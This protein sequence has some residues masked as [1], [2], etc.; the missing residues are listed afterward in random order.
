MLGSFN[1]LQ[2]L[3][4]TV[5]TDKLIIQGTLQTRL[6]RLTDVM[7]EPDLDHL[8]LFDAT[9]MELGSRRVL[10]SAG[11]SQIQLADALF[12]HTSSSTESGTAMRT[13][14]QPIQATVVAPPFTVEG[15]IHLPFE[16]EL[17]M[18]LDVF[19][20][21]FVPVTQAR[22]WAYGV[23]ESPIYVD[24]LVVNHAR[25]HFAIAAGTRWSGELQGPSA[26][27]AQNPW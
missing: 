17:H 15:E 14:K 10:A 27:G 7:N 16:V 4:L 24:L 9:F 1:P 26:G 21:R 3:P 13:P 8:V 23:A 22:Y 12:V 20:G 18:A 19:T 6:R 11:T 25:A 2:A 5:V